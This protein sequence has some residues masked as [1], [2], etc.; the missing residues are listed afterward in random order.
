M[1]ATS[2][3]Q[4]FFNMRVNFDWNFVNNRKT[5]PAYMKLYNPNIFVFFVM[6]FAVGLL[7]NKNKIK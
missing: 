4:D 5:V 2:R 6:I 7:N 3:I 1:F